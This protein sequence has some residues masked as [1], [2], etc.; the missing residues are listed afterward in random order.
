MGNKWTYA[1]L[2]SMNSRSGH[3]DFLQPPNLPVNS[4]GG[5]SALR[6]PPGRDQSS[7]GIQVPRRGSSARVDLPFDV[8]LLSRQHCNGNSITV[9]ASRG[10]TVIFLSLHLRHGTT[11]EE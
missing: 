10:L 3:Y 4:A 11:I 2:P 6:R 1:V 8:G 7:H 5:R 9:G